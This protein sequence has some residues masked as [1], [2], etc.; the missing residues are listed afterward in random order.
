MTIK[1]KIEIEVTPQQICDLFISAVEG[2]CV[3]WCDQM[4]FVQRGKSASY[5]EASS[6]EG[7]DWH[8]VVHAGDEDETFLVT[9]GSLTKAFE[10]NVHRTQELISGYYDAEDADVLIQWAAFGEIVYG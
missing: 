4:D 6:F 3:Y 2:G 7:G 8:V 1:V 5:Q 10:R 9:P